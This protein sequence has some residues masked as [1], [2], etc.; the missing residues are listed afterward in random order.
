MI[1]ITDYPSLVFVISLVLQWGSARIGAVLAKRRGNMDSDSHEDFGVVQAATLT[2][3]ALIIGFSF[4][5]A[6]SR[7][8]L[9][10]SYEENEANAIGT[11]YVRAD[12]LPPAQ[13]AAVRALLARYTDLRIHFYQTRDAQQLQQI[14][15]TTAQMQNDLWA[16]VRTSAAQQPTPVMALA[17]SGMNDVLNTQGY[18]QA[19]WWNRLP[20]AAW[21][22]MLL[23]AVCSNMLVGYGVRSNNGRKLLVVLPL[24]VSIAF[25]LIADIDSP[26][27]GVIRVKPQ[28][29]IAFAQSLPPH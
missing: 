19:E 5:M 8:D 23:M 28:N 29:L 9:R 21:T 10:K 26:R 18:T 2:L 16:A 17:V 20:L 1:N 7:Y 4:S 14:N 6:T 25:M 27:G 3:L 11:E 13:A 24:V 22:L 15:L 12:L